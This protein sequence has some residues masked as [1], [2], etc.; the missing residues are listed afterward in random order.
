[1]IFRGLKAEQPPTNVEGVLIL[2]GHPLKRLSTNIHHAGSAFDAFGSSISA[3]DEQEL[4][5]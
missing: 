3:N 4:S 1:M 5:A 2:S